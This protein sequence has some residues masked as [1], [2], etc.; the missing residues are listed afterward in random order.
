MNQDVFRNAL[1]AIIEVENSGPGGIEGDLN[2]MINI[3]AEVLAK[4]DSTWFE[5]YKLQMEKKG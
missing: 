5:N 4:Y 1:R 2:D 3:A